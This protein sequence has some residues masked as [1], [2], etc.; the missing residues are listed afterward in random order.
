MLEKVTRGLG[1]GFCEVGN[2]TSDSKKGG[3][4]FE[5]QF[6]KEK[7]APWIYLVRWLLTN[8]KPAVKNTDRETNTFIR[9]T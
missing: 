9:K 6:L 8:N 2:T 3:E 5:C 1:L 4:F 7:S